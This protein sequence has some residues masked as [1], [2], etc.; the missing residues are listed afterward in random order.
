MM[1]VSGGFSLENLRVAA[2][3]AGKTE[4]VEVYVTEVGVIQGRRIN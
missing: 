1:V 4:G 2:V 3:T